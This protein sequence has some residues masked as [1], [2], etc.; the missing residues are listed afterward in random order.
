M[1]CRPTIKYKISTMAGK[2]E[3]LKSNENR[4][5]KWEEKEARRLCRD[6]YDQL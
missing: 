1:K 2:T 4:T 3:R 5:M 6:V